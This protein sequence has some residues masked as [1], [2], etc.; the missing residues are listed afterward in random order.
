M[1]R[2]HK[3]A[4]R[5]RSMSWVHESGP[6]VGSTSGGRVSENYIKKSKY[7]EDNGAEKFDNGGGS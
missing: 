7:D 3:S 5:V 2:V 4:P 6:Q 1:S